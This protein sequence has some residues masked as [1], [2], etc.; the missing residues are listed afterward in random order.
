MKSTTGE[1]LT[2]LDSGKL[3]RRKPLTEHY[4]F[5]S[6]VSV[7]F[8]IISAINNP[9]CVYRHKEEELEKNEEK[10]DVRNINSKGSINLNQFAYKKFK[11]CQRDVTK[12]NVLT[13][14]T[15]HCNIWNIL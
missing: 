8:V 12:I 7:M 13:Q 15:C 14:F 9:I 6:H 5:I 10:L 2:R 1:P 4:I 11:N 3:R